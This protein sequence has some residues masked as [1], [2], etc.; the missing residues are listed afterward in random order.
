MPD[1]RVLAEFGS[2]RGLLAAAV[3]FIVV[4]FGTFGG[5][6][7]DIAPPDSLVGGA[8][9]SF[10]VGLA[11]FVALLLLLLLQA[12]ATAVVPTGWARIGWIV[13][14]AAA[15][16]VFAIAA[17]S[18]NESLQARTFFHAPREG[19]DPVRYVEGLQHTPLAEAYIKQHPFATPEE[20]LEAGHTD[21]PTVI[22]TKESLLN[23][24]SIL[25]RLYQ[26]VVVALCVSLF[27][28]LQ[29][30]IPGRQPNAP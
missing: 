11:S 8:H 5:F 6:L 17:L 19:G 26:V 24:G 1:N 16:V 22:W 4:L 30:L 15:G 12:L 27:S 20:L 13:L 18:Y 14:A 28:L 21:D 29:R 2:M 25:V 9:T 7:T 23:R 3:A 10:S